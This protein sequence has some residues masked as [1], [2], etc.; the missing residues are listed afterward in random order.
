[1]FNIGRT[2]G[3]K[4]LSSSSADLAF[5]SVLGGAAAAFSLFF[6]SLARCFCRFFSSL[7]LEEALISYKALYELIQT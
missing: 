7:L 1:M 4:L 6:S 2:F 5:F 3:V